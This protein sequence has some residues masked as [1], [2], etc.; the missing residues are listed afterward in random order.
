MLSRRVLW[1][2]YINFE[3]SITVDITGLTGRALL[4]AIGIAG[5]MS[6][7]EHIV[8]AAQNRRSLND[9]RLGCLRYPE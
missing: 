7:A 6:D 8:T 5:S 3:D 1:E 9:P 4:K 2:P